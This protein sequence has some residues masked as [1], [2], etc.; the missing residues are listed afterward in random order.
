MI[1]RY[2]IAYKIPKAMFDDLADAIDTKAFSV[3]PNS[4]NGFAE[5]FYCEVEWKGM[6]FAV[7]EF[8][9]MITSIDYLSGDVPKEY[10]LDFLAH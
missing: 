4:S 1:D 5:S 3:V 7:R 10:L 9:E 8:T 6:I 2:R